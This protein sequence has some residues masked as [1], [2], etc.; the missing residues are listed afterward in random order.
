M[1]HQSDHEFADY[2]G[3]ATIQNYSP[4]NAAR[5]NGLEN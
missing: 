3:G 5:C 2:A 4:Q 1:I